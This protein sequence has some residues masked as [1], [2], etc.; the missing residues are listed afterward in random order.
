MRLAEE[1]LR[2]MTAVEIVRLK[3]SFKLFSHVFSVSLDQRKKRMT[4]VELAK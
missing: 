2:T 1:A 3:V 4:H